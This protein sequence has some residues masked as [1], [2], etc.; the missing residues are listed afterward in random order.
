MFIRIYTGLVLSIVAAISC[1]YLVLT[2]ANE[3]RLTQ[4]TQQIFSGTFQLITE[5]ASRHT[6][7]KRDQWLNVV[8]QLIGAKLVVHTADS[9]AKQK[10]DLHIDI[11]DA[12]FRLKENETKVLI[13]NETT[14]IYGVISIGNS[15]TP[16]FIEAEI[17]NISEQHIRIGAFLILNELGRYSS[18]DQKEQL[19]LLQKRFAYP[20]SLQKIDNTQ[21]DQQQKKRIARGDVVVTFSQSKNNKEILLAY[22]PFDQGQV[23]ALGPIPVFDPTPMPLILILIALAILIT[24][25]VAYLMVRHLEKRLQ[26]V[27]QA[28]GTFGLG[29]MRT[30]VQIEGKDAIARLGFSM[31]S[32][33]DRI[34][35]LVINQKRLTQAVSHE[36][37]TPISR[38]KFRLEMLRTAEN[39]SE[40]ELRIDGMKQDILELDQLVDEILTHQQLESDVQNKMTL[41]VTHLLNIINGI[42]DESKIL[43]PHVIFLFSHKNLTDLE[44]FADKNLIKRLF[45][46]LISN[47]CKHCYSKV[48]IELRKH[49]QFVTIFVND[50]GEGI[51]KNEYESIFNPFVRLDNSRNRQTGGYGLGL[52][53]SRHI[54]QAH[55]GTLKAVEI[56]RTSLE[57]TL[58]GACFELVLALHTSGASIDPPSID[59][60]SDR[61]LKTLSK[62]TEN[63]KSDTKE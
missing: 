36:I 27:D 38:L 55:Q 37:R 28:L 24:A 14:H 11:I 51:P 23:L 49:P 63:F 16:T 26:Q 45:S 21:L 54:A 8:S 5:G 15:D 32:M 1:C 56:E 2:V 3:I 22:A 9:L 20:I 13:E 39:Q 30:R 35:E 12:L 48:R 33:A 46:N 29:D 7:N 52:A 31:N 62:N 18:A 42:I 40:R 41:E 44:I 19:L 53:I 25:M 4:H 58:P 10:H 43:Y 17:K 61:Q 59:G 57:E 6:G 34:S 47:A 50:D 60:S